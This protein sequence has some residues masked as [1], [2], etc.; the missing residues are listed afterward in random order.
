M[1]GDDVGHIYRVLLCEF[2]RPPKSALVFFEHLMLSSEV[3][4]FLID[5]HFYDPLSVLLCVVM[6]LSTVPLKI[7][8]GK[9]FFQDFAK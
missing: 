6:F 1:V 3:G 8:M 4:A 5:L 9:Q 2:Q 7:V